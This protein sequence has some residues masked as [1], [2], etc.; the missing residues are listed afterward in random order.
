[1]IEELQKVLTAEYTVHAEKNWFCGGLSFRV[2]RVFRGLG[3]VFLTFL[4]SSVCSWA[5]TY[6]N[7]PIRLISPFPPGGPVD[8][9]AR[10][11]GP[12]LTETFKQPIVVDNRPGASGMIGIEAG[13]RAAPDGYTMLIVS[14]TYAASAA[15][16]QLPYDPVNDVAPVVL[17]GGSP[18]LAVVHAS[19]PVTSIKELIAYDKANPGKVYYG[20]SGT[21]GSVH[22]ATEMFNQ[23]SG[24][25]LTHVPYKGQ[26]PALNDV[27]AAQ[28]QFLM[29]S[30]M[31]IYPHVKSGR[32]RGLAV[33][34]ARR[35]P[36]M[37]EI[38]ALGDTVAGYDTSSWQAILG[39]K[40]LPKEI[41]TLW[42]REVGRVLNLPDF[43]DRMASDG[44]EAG[45]GPPSRIFEVLKRDVLKWQRVVKA[46]NI[47]VGG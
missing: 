1:M 15:L 29:G 47:K 31:V 33:S 35:S 46:G 38:P 22:L 16:Y 3:F 18:H 32:L 5:Q 36:A 25:R 34:T 41:I 28:I 17:L 45:G 7:K 43:R 12:R 37:P 44:M 27:L 23:M 4:L 42:N 21:G 10:L 11:L 30:P 14:S 24:A 19:T 2:F 20:S 9:F 6:P 8:A 26:G 13:I 39:P 40:A